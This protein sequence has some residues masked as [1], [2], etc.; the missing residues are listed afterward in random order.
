MTFNK[1]TGEFNVK[2]GFALDRMREISTMTGISVEKLQEMGEAQARLDEIGR[3]TGR[4][5]NEDDLMLISKFAKFDENSK[6]W[7]ID[8][9]EFKGDI[10]NLDK[11][12]LEALREEQQSLEER[13]EAARTFDE[14][15]TDFILTLKQQ[16]L[17]FAP[18]LKENIGK[19]IQTLVKQWEK[20]GFFDTLKE[21]VKGA[22]ELISGIGKFI[23]KTAIWLGP[24]GTL[25]TI[26]GG[27]LLF[28]VGKWLANGMLLGKG[29]NSVAMAGGVGMPGS[30]FS[31]MSRGLGGGRGNFSAGQLMRSGGKN[32]MKGNFAKGGSRLLKGAGKGF[33]P[34]AL[35]GA[36]VDLFS[37]MSDDSMGVGEGLLKTLDQNKGMA[38]GAAIGSIIPGVGTLIGAGIGGIAD[39]FMGEI[40]EYGTVSKT[41]PST[42]LMNDGIVFH[43]QDKFMKVNDATMIAGTQAGGNAKL[44]ETLSGKM[45][46]GNSQVTHK[47]DDVNVK[48]EIVVPGTSELGTELAKDQAFIRRINE[49]ISEQ[50]TM[51]I[52][53]GK[54]SPNP[55][56]I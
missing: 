26:L 16:L 1:E 18:V 42:T 29:F 33:A 3:S 32:M 4:F 47:F 49:A 35:L 22:A 55:K 23:V 50:I 31:N 53:G 9:E 5:F 38:L 41:D 25:A 39:M 6:K 37:N 40:G 54:V 19:P 11:S 14:T 10:K 34:L 48:I 56:L 8:S 20:E 12:R 21:F 45:N 24:T 27:K 17:Q 28:N 2:G 44:A 51:V 52:G 15:I 7:V 13:A 43:P 46:G 36:G 30:N